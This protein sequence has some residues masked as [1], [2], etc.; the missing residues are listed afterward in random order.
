MSTNVL[1]FAPVREALAELIGSLLDDTDVGRID[2]G[3]DPVGGELVLS[4]H[5]RTFTALQRLCLPDEVDG[6][7][8]RLVVESY[9]LRG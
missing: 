8:V 6:V 4:V 7:A 1:E 2:L 9:P 3:S 5:L